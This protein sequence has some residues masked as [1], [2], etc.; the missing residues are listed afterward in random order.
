MKACKN[1]E[2]CKILVDEWQFN[3]LKANAERYAIVRQMNPRQFAA[4]W[5]LNI[6][7]G[8]PFDE[9]ISDLAPFAGLNWT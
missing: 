6:S 2:H 5:Q 7:T 1:C 3:Q 9:I 8:K 4:A